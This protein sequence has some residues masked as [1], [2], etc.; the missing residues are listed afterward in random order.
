M[1]RYVADAAFFTL[2]NRGLSGTDKSALIAIVNEAEANDYA[3][4]TQYINAVN[5]V[6]TDGGIALPTDA[7]WSD[8][9]AVVPGIKTGKK[10]AIGVKSTTNGTDYGYGSYGLLEVTGLTFRPSAIL[11]TKETTIMP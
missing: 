2:R 6:D 1:W 9:L 4:K 10:W 5:A 11:A 3:L 7:T 8:I